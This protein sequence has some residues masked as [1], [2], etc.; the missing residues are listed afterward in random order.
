MSFRDVNGLMLHAR[1]GKRE[2]ARPLVFINSLGTDYRI[3]HQVVHALRGEPFRFLL[4]DKR[5]HGLSDVGEPPY[6]IQDHADDVA[7]LME[8]HGMKEAIICGISVGG[9]IALALADA[10]P[11]LVAGLVICGSAH[12]IGTREAWDKRIA[13]VARSGLAHI[14]PMI[15]QAWFTERYRTER[16]ADVRGWRNMV[17]RCPAGGYIGTCMAIRDA[18]YTQAA[19]NISVPTKVLAAAEDGSTPP[20]LVKSL[21]D[22]VPGAEYHVIEKAAHMMCIEQPQA[23]AEH[24]RA[25]AA[26]H[27][28]I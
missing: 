21:A 16:A 7:A 8:Q 1:A 22:L 3:W 26:A 18:D 2:E 5:G 17:V 15:E 12:K 24:I 11:D 25:F 9:M 10:R 4:H 27:G 28:L 6:S 19:Q 14:W 23:V 20:E 13:T